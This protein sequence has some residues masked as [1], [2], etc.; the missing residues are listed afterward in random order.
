MITIFQLINKKICELLFHRGVGEGAIPAYTV[1]LIMHMKYE[2]IKNMSPGIQT[3]GG[4]V[5]HQDLLVAMLQLT[6]LEPKASLFIAYFI[7]KGT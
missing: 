7:H 5:A 1:K 3:R 2:C 6:S 4:I